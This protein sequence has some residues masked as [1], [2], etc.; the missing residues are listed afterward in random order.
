MSAEEAADAL[1]LLIAQD[2][3]ELNFRDYS[4]SESHRELMLS[5]P[6]YLHIPREDWHS[7]PNHQG[8]Y[9]VHYHVGFREHMSIVLRLLYRFHEQHAAHAAGRGKLRE[10]TLIKTLMLF[11]EGCNA[12]AGHVDYE[13]TTYF[14]YLSKKHSGVDLSALYESHTEL[15]Q[16]CLL[17]TSDAADEEDSVDLGGL[18]I[19]QKHKTDHFTQ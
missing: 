1:E 5:M 14:P 8:M 2:R 4:T 9:M 18:R 19:L 7:H 12:L 6:E 15:H 10:E 16:V 3:R 11:R 13:E 17:Y